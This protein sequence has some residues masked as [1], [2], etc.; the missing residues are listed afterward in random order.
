M[1]VTDRWETAAVVHETRR[2][3]T[4]TRYNAPAGKVSRHR[5]RGII[6]RRPSRYEIVKP[7]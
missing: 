1:D 5:Q 2:V 6:A 3:R 7:V 4:K